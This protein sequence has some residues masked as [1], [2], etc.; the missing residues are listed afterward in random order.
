MS[1]THDAALAPYRGEVLIRPLGTRE[2]LLV[3]VDDGAEGWAPVAA[4]VADAVR[5]ALGVKDGTPIGERRFTLSPESLARLDTDRTQNVDGY[6]R[7]VL[8]DGE[9]KYSHQILLKEAHDAPVGI[10]PVGVMVAVQLAAMQ[11]QL[12]RMEALFERGVAKIEAIRD[13]L[14]VQQAAEANAALAAI[15]RVYAD[16]TARGGTVGEVDWSRLAHLEHT[17]GRAL[18][19]VDQELEHV[20]ARL[21]FTGKAATDIKTVNRFDPDRVVLLVRMHLALEEGTRRWV[22]LMGLRKHEQGEH[23]PVAI[24]RH[25]A[26]L[27]AAAHHRQDLVG[28]ILSTV[29][30][31]RRAE[32]RPWPELLLKQG[33][34]GGWKVDADRVAEVEAFKA[35]VKSSDL[36]SASRRLPLPS[37][38]RLVIASSPEPSERTA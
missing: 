30:S 31:A 3:G 9:G 11:A 36:L 2:V 10:D 12:D 37:P 19:A 18:D 5:A 29:E 6:F 27:E 22:Y 32:G 7:G 20:A 26:D 38:H 8:M 25:Y 16:V 13:H 34:L 21:R 1:A 4:A 23:D 14:E 28:Q 17:L 33:L 15:G 24:E 35:A